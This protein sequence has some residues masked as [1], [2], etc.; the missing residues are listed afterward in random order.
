MLRAIQ[1]MLLDVQCDP[2][3]ASDDQLTTEELRVPGRKSELERKNV[4][5]GVVHE[6]PEDGTA[7]V[8]IWQVM[9]V[10]KMRYHLVALMLKDMG[11]R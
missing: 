9:L 3:I 6:Q 8:G 10:P 4:V 5:D 1:P 11:I 2:Q 7:M